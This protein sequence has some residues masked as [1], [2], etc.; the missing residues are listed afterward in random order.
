MRRRRNR[1]EVRGPR[2]A[3][4]V[5]RRLEADRRAYHVGLVAARLVAGAVLA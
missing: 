1:I 3:E 4:A 5:N 2:T